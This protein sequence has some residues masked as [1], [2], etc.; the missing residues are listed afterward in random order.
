MA[1]FFDTDSE[2]TLFNIGPYQIQR[3]TVLAPMAGVT[4]LPFRQ[5]CRELGAGLVVSEM[6]ASDP[7]TWST[8]KSNCVSSLP[9]SGPRIC[10]DCRLRSPDDGRGRP[11]QCPAGGADHRYQYGL[12]GE[13]S[14]EESRRFCPAAV[15]GSGA[16]ILHAVV[17][18]VD[19]PVTLKIRTGWDRLN[20]NAVSIARIAEDAGI[21]ALAIH[22]A[23][24]P[25]ALSKRWSTTPLPMWSPLSPCRCWP[26]AISPRRKKPLKCCSI[27]VP[28]L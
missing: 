8:K 9:M 11:L 24:A 28:L 25:A 6:V 23:P 16:D 15:P 7:S 2:T 17:D 20:R 22:G 12:P 21:A 26:M 19:V 10:A 14:T 18:S 1:A 5:L 4:D 13:K 27:P 3:K